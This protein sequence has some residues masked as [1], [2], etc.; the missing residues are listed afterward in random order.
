MQEE[1]DKLLPPG[2]FLPLAEE[3]GLLHVVDR[4]VVR[5]V[6]DHAA[7]ARAHRDSVY[8]VNLSA[9]TIRDPGFAQFVRDCL[10]S[11]RVPDHTLCFELPEADVLADP[12]AYR[13]FIGGLDGTGC[14]FAVSASVC[15]LEVIRLLQQLRVDFLKLDGGIVLGMLRSAAGL[16]RVKAI[17]ETAH[18]AGMRIVAECVEDENTRAALTRIGIDFAQGFGIAMPRPIR[19]LDEELAL[20]EAAREIEM[21]AA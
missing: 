11:S 18:A 1:E 16:A 13:E 21:L 5:H 12:A 9:P 14:R 4:W 20:E 3:L 19:A 6:V 15:D 7:K 8:F 17:N 10:K 2:T